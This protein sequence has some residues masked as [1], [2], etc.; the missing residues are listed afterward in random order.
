MSEPPENK[1]LG[2]HRDDRAEDGMHLYDNYK[3]RKR[4]MIKN[5]GKINPLRIMLFMI[6]WLSIGFAG[7]GRLY[8]NALGFFVAFLIVFSDKIYRFMRRGLK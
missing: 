6:I 5:T 3:P 8:F 1:N 4:D 2:E 7:Q